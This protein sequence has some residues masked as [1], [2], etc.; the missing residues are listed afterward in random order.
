MDNTISYDFFTENGIGEARNLLTFFGIQNPEAVI[1][2]KA[3]SD[4][5]EF[6]NIDIKQRFYYADRLVVVD[7][8]SM[9]HSYE[10]DEWQLD[11][12]A[13]ALGFETGATKIHIIRSKATFFYPDGEIV[14]K[15]LI[16]ETRKKGFRK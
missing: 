11:L 16:A 7:T 13:G 4:N 3:E 9:S 8:H 2:F 10:E 12:I 6:W 14:T 5:K 15:H 1:E